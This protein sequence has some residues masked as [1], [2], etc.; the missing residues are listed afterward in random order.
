MKKKSI[1]IF[2]A[3]LLVSLSSEAAGFFNDRISVQGFLKQAGAPLNDLAG[4][5][6]TFVVKKNG[7]SVWCQ[8][9]A[10]PVVVADGVFSEILSGAAN[11][12]SLSNIISESTFVSSSNTD[13]FTIDV[14]VDVAK[15]GFGGA[16]DASFAGIDIL[17]ATF[18]LNAKHANSADDLSSTLAL[19]KG[20]TGASTAAGART[21]LGLGSLATVDAPGN[22]GTVLLGDGTFATPPAA[23]VSGDISGT[24]STVSVDKIKGRSLSATAPSGSQ[25]LTWNSGTSVWEPQTPSSSAVASVAGKVGVVVL[26][27]A[28]V[29]DATNANTASTI[30]KRDASGNFS[31]GTI[32]ATLTGNAT[33]VSG[34]V[35]VANGGTGATTA[36]GARTA[37]SA[38]A[39]GANTDITSITGSAK[40]VSSVFASTTAGTTAAYT[41]TNS[42][43]LT[44]LVTGQVI[45]VV[46]NA[47]N[48][49]SATLNVDGLGA[50][51]I[52][53]LLTG[54][55]VA[56]GDL[57]TAAAVEM[58]YNG[59][60]WMAKIPPKHF[61]ATSLTCT[62]PILANSFVVCSNIAA[63]NVNAGDVVNCSPS[64]DPGNG[65]SA[66][67]VTWSAVAT[68]GNIAIRMGCNNG[69]SNCVLAARNWKC[70][71]TK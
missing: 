32:T 34:T 18:A 52:F 11:C 41:L 30:V 71:V 38:A 35:A 31:A 40:Q 16:D 59:T 70:A 15:N 58:Y 67:T 53:S 23:S 46:L 44:S 48:A 62:S 13:V 27:S 6:M 47:V 14:M 64:S 1:Y 66:G 22:A 36:A 25:V 56:A 12:Q 45:F 42:P 17:P 51:P 39:S 33:N 29:S 68:A 20:G 61:S 50:K 3:T 69:A 24:T 63:T 2:L 57:P 28:D 8:T 60:Q 49:A 54:A 19:A 10:S 43:A 37:L 7:T 26:N 4:F 65:G 5:P 9:S 55:A 21:N